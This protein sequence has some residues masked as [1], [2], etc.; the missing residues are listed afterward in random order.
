[1]MKI[2]VVAFCCWFA[3]GGAVAQ[4]AEDFVTA[5]SSS[6]Q[7]QALA[8]RRPGLPVATAQPSGVPGQ[9]ILNSTLQPGSDSQLPLDPSL[10]VFSCE[11]IKEAFLATLDRRDQWRGRI[12]LLINP[13]LPEGQSPVLEGVYNPK[14]WNYRLTLPSPIEPKLYFRTIVS[15][16]LMEMAN[17]HAGAQ[18]A[19]VPLWLAAG[20]S[21]RMQADNLPIFLLRPQSRLVGDWVADPRVDPV[22]DQLRR[23]PPLTFQELCW[24]ES[25][26]PAGQDYDLYAAC[27]Q[28]FVGKLLRFPDGH[29]CLDAMIDKLPQ[30]LNWQTSF[31]EAFS[32][33]F[34]RLLDVE[35]WWMLACVQFTDVDYAAR[36]SPGD[37]WHRLQ[38]ALDVPVEVHF[39]PDRLPAQAEITLQEVINTWQ[40][41]RAAD[42]LQRA[43]D[44]LAVLRARIAPDLRPLLE[45][46]LSTLRDYLGE[47]LPNRAVLMGKETQP[48][49]TGARIAA[50]K[51]L[52]ALDA[53][54]AAMRPK[55]VLT[56]APSQLSAGGRPPEP[57]GA[58]QPQE[59]QP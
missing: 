23:Q 5:W 20:L 34:A 38:E 7:F 43:A 47:S 1:M 14:G 44:S 40:P 52:D 37:S 58:V 49:L 27:A 29:R 48:Q 9:F 11:R 13:D 33:H 53:Q 35:K 50:C 22:R 4:P 45:H 57:P 51:A 24:P 12:T 15:A 28:L 36:F 42:T 31:L 59:T 18:T 8:P 21:A 46:Y 55:Y 19:E 3:A 32:P 25:E 17:R 41:A 54:R 2:G 26:G 10:L 30:H 6:G 56:P 39:S 16:L